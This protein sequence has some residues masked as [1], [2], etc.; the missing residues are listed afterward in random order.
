MDSSRGFEGEGH[1]GVELCG[2]GSWKTRE[3]SIVI[4]AGGGGERC[5]PHDKVWHEEEEG[6][7]APWIGDTEAH[8]FGEMVAAEWR[9]RDN[10]V[11]L[12]D[13]PAPQG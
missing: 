2:E 9:V 7:D 13:F 3:R 6:L 8:D 12:R 5:S 10:Y 1:R 4:C 11:V